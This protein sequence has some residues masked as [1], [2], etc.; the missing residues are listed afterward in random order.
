MKTLFLAGKV[1]A[2]AFIGW[3][4]IL[5]AQPWLKFADMAAPMVS[6][7][8]FAKAL[9]SIPYLGGWLEFL[10]NNMAA[11]VGLAA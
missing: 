1:A 11:I 10:G 8:P 5:N 6:N 2:T 4:M 9:I 7:V 3:L